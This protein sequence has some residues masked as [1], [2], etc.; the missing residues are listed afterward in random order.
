MKFLSLLSHL[1]FVENQLHNYHGYQYIA[2]QTEYYNMLICIY[3]VHACMRACIIIFRLH[4]YMRAYYTKQFLIYAFFSDYILVQGWLWTSKCKVTKTYYTHMY[5]LHVA[6]CFIW[7][8]VV[9]YLFK[10]YISSCIYSL[11]FSENTPQHPVVTPL[12]PP[13]PCSNTS[14]KY[15]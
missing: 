4:V 5:C 14:E 7:L 2:K 8:Y 12:T 1:N 13:T 9:P 15:P 6:N 3:F 10:W 11:N